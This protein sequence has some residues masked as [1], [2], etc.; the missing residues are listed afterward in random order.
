LLATYIY[1]SRNKRVIFLLACLYIG[2]LVALTIFAGMYAN[3]LW[4]GYFRADALALLFLAL[5]TILSAAAVA[6]NFIYSF[7]RDDPP[8]HMAIHFSAL[9]IFI[10]T[11]SGVLLSAHV[12]LMWAFL[13]ATTLAGSALIYFHRNALSLEATW[14]YVFVCS[15]GIALAFTGILF[16][17]IASQKT[18]MLDLSLDALRQS[19]PAMHPLWL[20]ICFLFILAGFSV[21][22]G[23]APLFN[24]DIDAKDLAPSPVGA[25]FSSALMNTG[26]VAI[27]RF[28]ESFAQ[29]TILPWMNKT[30]MLTGFVSIF[31]ATIYL[32]KVRS[33][34]R[35]FAYSS[36]EH[37]GIAVLALSAGGLGYFAAILHLILHALTKSSLFFQLGQ[38]YRTFKS[39]RVD[40]VG[41]YFKRNPAGGVVLIV[42]FLAV[43]GMPPTGLFFSE[44][45]AFKALI[46]SGYLWLVI[47]TFI[48]LAFIIGA[49]SS[50]FFSLLFGEPVQNPHSRVAIHPLESATQWLFMLIVIALGFY[51]P[52]FLRNMIHGAVQY[53][54]N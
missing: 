18:E 15:I 17:S 5:L 37:A 51:M 34:K 44:L 31:F 12:G 21:K 35:M 54:P 3:Q 43:T 36:L 24:V 1:F 13:E 49:M 40:D 19:A 38:V 46:V 2:I 32:L 30:L 9:V 27:F 50:K 29:T 6:H 45:F 47:T 14:K 52:D 20:K 42:G 28:Y 22:M 41:G 33:Y 23:L 39:M 16:L 4:Y 53:L 8:R 7:H 11:M 10:T 48:L 26:F 25:L